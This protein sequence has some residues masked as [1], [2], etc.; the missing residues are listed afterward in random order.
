MISTPVF[1]KSQ[2]NTNHQEQTEEI[3]FQRTPSYKQ[4][5]SPQ[6]YELWQMT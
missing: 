1:R 4:D 3:M 2:V 5:S 6:M